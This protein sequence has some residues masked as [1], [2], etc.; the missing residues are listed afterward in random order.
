VGMHACGSV[1]HK[2]FQ[3]TAKMM[4]T[5]RALA[6]LMSVAVG[7]LPATA[8][9]VQDLPHHSSVDD[10]DVNQHGESGAHVG[11]TR[12]VGTTSAVRDAPAQQ[13]LTV[14]VAQ[15]ASNETTTPEEMALH[16]IEFVAQAAARGARVVVF[17][18]MAVRSAA[19]MH[20]AQSDH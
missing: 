15:T 6:M 9:P 17:P 14:A 12:W 11:R 8:R 19:W 7:L 16:M 18:E 4:H 13:N 20:H 3:H 1:A 10:V 2:H 5:W